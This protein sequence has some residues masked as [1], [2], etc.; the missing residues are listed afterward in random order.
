MLI[1]AIQNTSICQKRNEKIFRLNKSMVIFVQPD[2]QL[3]G[4]PGTV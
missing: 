1:F 4:R 3:G 2:R